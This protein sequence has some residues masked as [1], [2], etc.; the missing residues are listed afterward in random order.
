MTDEVTS[1]PDGRR[2]VLATDGS[3]DANAALLAGMQLLGTAS[4][5]LLVTVIPAAD[6][7]LVVGS[8]HA[9]PAM[10][11]SEKA[12]LM[13]TRHE[14]AQAL[15]QAA[16]TLL[17]EQTCSGVLQTQ[18]LEG[19]PGGTICRAAVGLGAAAIVMGTRGRGGLKRAL[20][21]SVSDHVVRNA[22]CPVITV[23]SN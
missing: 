12:D 11:P 2:L 7:S 18:I 6:P 9:G 5:C 1:S 4:S 13:S 8:G 20:L 22:P 17:S 10:T 16:A 19:D 14:E 23:N 3:D 21:G 15:L